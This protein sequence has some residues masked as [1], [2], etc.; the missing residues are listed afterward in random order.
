[1]VDRN[2]LF[3][4]HVRS[5]LKSTSLNRPRNPRCLSR[6]VQE[7]ALPFLYRHQGKRGQRY[8]R[9]N[10]N[11]TDDRNAEDFHITS[12]PMEVLLNDDGLM[13]CPV[14]TCGKGKV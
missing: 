10:T 13:E 5:I 8:N 9:M 14:L 11:A 3:H 1:M 4:L 2:D 7:I 6:P 12:T